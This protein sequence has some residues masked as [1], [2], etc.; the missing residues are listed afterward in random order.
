MCSDKDEYTDGMYNWHQKRL[1]ILPQ[2][3]LLRRLDP[4]HVVSE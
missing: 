4:V 3:L 1:N 2:N